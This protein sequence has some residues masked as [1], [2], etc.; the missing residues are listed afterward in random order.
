MTEEKSF[1]SRKKGM[2]CLKALHATTKDDHVNAYSN[3]EAG[4]ITILASIHFAFWRQGCFLKYLSKTFSL[5]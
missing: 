1:L 4:K 2:A 3:G 5:D